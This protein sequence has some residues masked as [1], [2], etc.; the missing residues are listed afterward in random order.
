MIRTVS[1]AWFVGAMLLVA[2]GGKATSGGGSGG[3]AGT[4]LDN[5]GADAGSETD[6]GVAA[7]DASVDPVSDA[8]IDSA[9]RQCASTFGSA[10]TASY[11]RIDG[12]LYAVILPGD[13]SCPRPNSD[14]VILEVMMNGDVYRLLINVQSDQT[15][16]DANVQ[17]AE[18]DVAIPGGPFAE[19]WHTSGFL[20]DYFR[21]FNVHAADF[22]EYPKDALA[23]KVAAALTIGDPISVFATGYGVDGGHNIHRNGANND[24]AVVIHP[25]LTTP[26]VLMFHFADQTF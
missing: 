25:E 4:N 3:Q 9:P 19:G 16:G 7:N 23:A 12:T 18:R 11:G 24:G 14:H 22:V 26:H 2:C 21:T 6:G 5:P 1:G 8:A 20:V 10:L 15:V 17:F 13:E